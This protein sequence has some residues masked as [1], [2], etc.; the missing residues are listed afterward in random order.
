MV[1]AADPIELLLPGA[2][3][4]VLGRARSVVQFLRLLAND[5]ASVRGAAVGV[6]LDQARGELEVHDRGRLSGALAD[7]LRHHLRALA[8]SG[9]FLAFGEP[10]SAHDEAWRVLEELRGE[11]PR[12][13]RLPAPGEPAL[14][15][16]ARLL[17]SFDAIA[18]SPAS[19]A[20]WKARLARFAEGPR[21]AEA[22]AKACLAED[23]AVDPVRPRIEESTRRALIACAA[24]C[25]LDRGAV[26]EAR[27]W[28]TEHASAAEGDPRIRQLLSWSRLALGDYAA[29]KSA[30]VGVPPGSS[31]LPAGL[32]ELRAHKPEWL[33]CLAGR[34][35]SA[36]PRS[37]E[38]SPSRTRP[39][40]RTE[41]GASVLALFAL[42]PGGGTVL[43]HLD[44]APGLRAA[45]D[46]WLADRDGICAT[47]GGREHDL[48]ASARAVV[49]HRDAERPIAGALGGGATLALA[50]SPIVDAEGEVQGWL[51]AECEHHLLP[52]PARLAALARAWGEAVA[53]RC[54][55]AGAARSEKGADVPAALQDPLDEIDAAAPAEVFRQLVAEL[56]I[57]TAQRR[58][59]GFV[60]EAGETRLVA[61]GGEAA[62]LGT[63]PGGKGR[64]LTRAIATRGRVSFDE[65]DPFLALDARAGSGTVLPLSAG[66]R[67]CG[68]LAVE[69][70]RRRDFGDA[71]W[72]RHAEAAQRSGLALQLARFRGWH[73]ARQGCDVWFDAR[74]GDFRDFALHLLA[75]A[76][77]R[78]PIVLFG[79]A[80][81]GKR[82]LARWL[83]FESAGRE[84][85][86]RFVPCG[87]PSPRGSLTECL[88]AA[89][90]G[91]V[92][93]ADV[94]QLDRERQEELLRVLE[95]GSRPSS[96]AE[97]ARVLAT[98][99][100]SL[101]ESVES[102]RLR[103][104]LAH[105]LD[106]LQ[107]RV[108]P[109][110]ERREDIPPLVECLA[111]RFAEEEG[112][113][114][115]TFDDDA[116]AFLWRQRWEGN[117]R[118]LESFVY[119]L[120]LLA[121]VDASPRS[122]SIDA[123]LVRGM[124]GR[125]SAK[126][127]RRLPSRHPSPGDL[128]AALR[129]TRMPGG[130]TNKTRAALY[131]GW[132][133]DTLVARMKDCGIADEVRDEIVWAAPAEDSDEE[134]A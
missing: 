95:D 51:H 28:L 54:D 133:P 92:V 114:V 125:F 59:W 82:V 52:D 57:K 87:S 134:P 122:R 118:E 55:A 24:E 130:R 120:V 91:S 90:S 39:G 78:S 16:A 58:W 111:R 100:C 73:R 124:A 108:P 67:L 98:T 128:I 131:L 48:V 85:P 101:R 23:D 32:A 97:R 123:D 107:F 127:V 132:D 113:R 88:S 38:E 129:V 65:P 81:V 43:L 31:S 1:K 116:L 56:A 103:A 112:L 21:A 14:E 34:A 126:L 115:P 63:R 20:L 10:A 45:V 13:A 35:A 18:G 42:E 62:E 106:R 37:V 121:R 9:S 40:G 46:G 36:R 102:G 50:L 109:L 110:V 47:P 5:A 8:G 17:A 99:A 66:G 11:V 72:A 29:A 3:E 96:G 75:A 77:S 2:G 27:E 30:I 4:D 86:I 61:T 33:P 76:R 15:T 53:E 83:H 104:D 94:D 22:I 41:I 26:R 60:H 49:V 25:L 74:R 68:L 44:V 12:L 84:G 70:I 80:G 105:R 71:E 6:G 19:S 117:V 64:A 89:R 119:K 79:A 93:L 7:L 69:S